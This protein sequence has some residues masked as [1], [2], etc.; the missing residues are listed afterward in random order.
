MR[1]GSSQTNFPHLVAC[2]FACVFAGET[3]DVSAEVS[4]WGSRLLAVV[5]LATSFVEL[6]AGDRRDWLHWTGIVTFVAITVAA[7]LWTMGSWFFR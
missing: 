4:A 1:N 6:A 5:I 7:L 2:D 3:V